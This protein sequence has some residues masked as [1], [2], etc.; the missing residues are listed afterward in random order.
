MN[1]P[2]NL[3]FED[4]ER[5]ADRKPNLDGDFIYRLTQ[6][7]L[8]PDKLKHPYPKFEL[9]YESVRLFNSFD[10][11]LSFLKENKDDELYCSW[12]AQLP[13]GS[14]DYERTAEWFY[15]KDGNLLDYSAQKCHGDHDDID[16]CFFGRPAYRQRFKEG[17]IVEVVSGKEVSLA[18]LWSPPT[19]VEWCWNYYQ[20]VLADK[21]Y[22]YYSLDCSDDSAYVIDGPSHYCHSHP[23]PLQLMKPRFPVPP[24]IEAEMRTW[25]ERADKETEEA[26]VDFGS[27]KRSTKT[28]TYND[29]VCSDIYS[30]NLYFKYNDAGELLLLLDD[31]YGLRV[32][33][34]TSSAA[35][36]DYEDFTCRLTDSQLRALQDYLEDVDVGKSKWWY[37]IRQWNEDEDHRQIPADTPLPDYTSLISNPA[38][39]SSN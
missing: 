24:E 6:L 14:M 9:G 17:D 29:Y 19:G 10:D 34:R 39:E 28:V 18:L 26:T 11:A 23:S 12:I 7:F 35:Y 25:K 16:Y 8:D 1:I 13:N 30:F 3:T 20:R 15:D 31:N 27:R 21:T 2:D 22:P 5:L 32:S 4:F 37:L 38:E 36:A 33:L